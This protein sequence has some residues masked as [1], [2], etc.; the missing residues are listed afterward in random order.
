[1]RPF[2]SLLLGLA[3][4]A[5]ASGAEW[6]WYRSYA[7]SLRPAAD[8]TLSY[9]PR[10]RVLVEVSNPHDFDL[11]Q[12]PV[13]IRRGEL[14]INNLYEDW[15]T[16]VDPTLPAQAEPPAEEI[17][18]R[19]TVI[20]GRGENGLHLVYQMDDLDK[21]GLWDELFFQVPN[22]KA[23]ETRPILIYFGP[24]RH[25]LYEHETHAEIGSYGKHTV[26]WWESKSIGWKLW[27]I[28]SVDMY[29]KRRPALVANHENTL[30]ISGHVAPME[31][32]NDIMW[33]AQ[34]F[35]TGGIC[36]LEDPAQPERVARPRF[37]TEAPELAGQRFIGTNLGR[38]PMFD[39]R[40]AFHVIVNGPLRS[41][42]RVDTMN[43]N[44]AAGSYELRQWFTAYAHENYSTVRTEFTRL[45]HE[46][47][48]VR[49]GVGM[50]KMMNETEARV[51]GGAVVSHGHKLDVFDVN[52]ALPEGEKHMI[53]WIGIAIAVKEE[54]GAQY[55]S[56][57]AQDGNHLLHFAVPAGQAFD[58]IMLGGWSDGYQHNTPAAFEQYVA[59][60]VAVFNRPP[61]VRI[62]ELEERP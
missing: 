40:A 54:L 23:G 51:G 24:D 13:V 5:P 32:G 8:P 7:V 30:N 25:G 52:T 57:E 45:M 9:E 56:M 61:L 11:P 37:A 12:A 46:D 18:R 33:V 50:R 36:V 1:M 15:I 19:G 55:H 21:D 53:D 49:L 31:T 27:F 2:L 44:T 16:P 3:L 34:T 35:G 47:G 43:W 58:Y 38:G 60:S 48:D 10:H 59:R 41:M 20:K 14:P 26:P 39:T 22:L 4:L 62:G 17:W 28:D 6:P 42:I 29:A